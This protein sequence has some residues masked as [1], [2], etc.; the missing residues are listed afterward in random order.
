MY[1]NIKKRHI[2]TSI[3]MAALLLFYYATTVDIESISITLDY[4]NEEETD[5][6]IVQ[7]SD[8]H[9]PK[10]LISIDRIIQSVANLNADI[11]VMTGD[12]VDVNSRSSLKAFEDLCRGL[13]H[14]AR[15]LYVTGN[16]EMRH[17]RY[18]L[19]MDVLN[20]NNVVLLDNRCESFNVN[21]IQVAFIGI[22]DGS[23]VE[24]LD[25]LTVEMEDMPKVMLVHRPEIFVNVVKKGA[26]FKPD[27][28][29]SGHIHGGQFRIP[30]TNIGLLSPDRSFFPQYT[31][32]HYLIGNKTLLVSRGLG[33]SIIPVRLF[34]RPHIISLNI[35]V[36]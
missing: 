34:N 35:K 30:F 12:I 13:T 15:V 21:G 32:G 8:V 25:N 6:R 36:K 33:N 2:Y 27:I 18:D 5:L 9:I 29:F 31:S 19:I 1:K 26:S 11:I 22:T 28:G 7:I 14:E 23:K 16:H 3:V 17:R 20:R 4:N 10:E 24:E